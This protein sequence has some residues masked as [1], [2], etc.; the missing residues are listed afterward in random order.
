[1]PSSTRTVL[2]VD[3][4]PTAREL[5]TRLFHRVGYRVREASAGDQ[6]LAQAQREQPGLA[7]L[8]VGLPGISGYELCRELKDRFGPEL[9]VVLV[10]GE[11]TEPF[12]RVG[13]LLMGADDYIVKPFDPDEVLARARRLLD[14]PPAPKQRRRRADSDA[15]VGSLTGRELEVLRL[16]AEGVGQPAIARELVITPKTVSTHI[17]RIL[18]KLGVHNQ[19]Q[20]VAAAYRLGL[21]DSSDTR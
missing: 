13:G 15:N 17:Q 10:S 3:S 21:N 8:D 14:R 12:D 9:P 16:L 18:A 20:A 2:V 7:I 5:L 1:L 4:D 6:A 19:A 11:R